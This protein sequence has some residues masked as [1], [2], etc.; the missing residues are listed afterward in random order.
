MLRLLR[1][2]LKQRPLPFTHV[3][4]F[5]TSTPKP[6]S[7]P[8]NSSDPKSFTVSYLRKSCGL[9]LESAVSAA[10]KLQI[11][12]KHSPDSVLSLFK[13]HGLNQ[14]QIRN[15][16][17]K[18]P[19]LLLADLDG[20][21]RP[22]LEL[23][24]SLGLSGTSLAQVILKEPTALEND[25]KSVLECFRS[26]GFS[27]EEILTLTM[28]LPT[29]YTY[30]AE[31]KI[32]PKLEFLKSVGFSELDI[33]KVVSSEPYILTRSLKNQ[34]IP[35]IEI[36][37]RVLGSEEV[38]VKVVK[39]C[40]RIL[41]KP[42]DKL[43]E[44]NIDALSSNGVPQSLI[45]K[46]LVIHPAVLLL[47]PYQVSEGIAF[48]KGLGFNP[49]SL[50]FLLAVRS[51]AGM[52]KA[53]WEQKQETF[54]SCGM[55]KD[56]IDSAFKVQPM[57]MVVSVKKIQKMMN[58]YLSKVHLNPLAIRKNPNLLFYSL[59]KRVIP[60]CS[61]LQLLLSHDLIREDSNY[62]VHVIRMNEEAFKEKIISKYKDVVPDVIKAHKGMIEFEGFS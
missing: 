15:I 25:A 32:K 4:L 49:N 47:S 41:E 26:H 12:P 7:K 36:L 58:F 52:S 30:D 50:K 37:R 61:V 17:S 43:L 27:E 9:S 60:R 1:K 51:V 23:L 48:V 38:V 42:L 24:N 40:Y 56:D 21:I 44:Q 19:M 28:K 62:F 39:R 54:R 20:K 59:E 10:Q 34:I 22:N 8:S 29:L 6:I 11:E 33:A 57:C 31:K 14:T 18:R 45:S 2:N 5:S 16:I 46:L 55:S 53:L 3:N 35:S 13:T